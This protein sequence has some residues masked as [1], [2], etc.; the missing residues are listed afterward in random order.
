M[1]KNHDFKVVN[2]CEEL[3]SDIILIALRRGVSVE[4]DQID[5]QGKM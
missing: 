1:V 5:L 3:I 4:F 2:E